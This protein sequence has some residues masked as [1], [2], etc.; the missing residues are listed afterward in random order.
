MSADRSDDPI[1]VPATSST[2]AH[3]AALAGLPE[4]GPARLRGLLADDGPEM[5]W[6]RVV[7]GRLP[8]LVQ[9]RLGARAEPLRKL[10]MDAA[11]DR[12]VAEVWASIV[13]AGFTVVTQGGPGYPEAL[14]D[15]PE[16]PVLLFT[17]GHPVLDDDRPRVAIVGTR[18][19]TGYGRDVAVELGRGLAAAGVVVVSGLA[20]GIDA[21]AHLGALDAGGAPPV[22][23][24][25]TGLDVVYP[26]TNRRLWERVVE[27]GQVVSEMPP[28]AGPTR[29][30]FPAR[31]RIVAGLAD[32]VVVVESH[33]EGGSLHTVASALERSRPVLVV[34]GPIRSP[35]SAGSNQLLADGAAPVCGIDDVLCALDLL[36]RGPG[37]GSTPAQDRSPAMAGD[38]VTGDA[39]KALDALGW[40]PVHP[41]ALA[42]RTDLSPIR[43]GVAVA[44][45]R[46]RG[47]VDEVRGFLERRSGPL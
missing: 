20:L 11:R 13:E 5:A 7:A 9:H 16:P 21:A 33:A 14:V 12:S 25:G 4:M 32:V 42:A 3:L 26:P 30:C 44:E 2:E 31:N 18:R 45:L 24:V 35:A 6:S 41:D 10:W 17:A 28:G 38:G 47:L 37:P 29:W 15:D 1:A 22:G 40:E 43:L 23:V 34:P 46:R 27:V 19:C 36:G 8:P 39:A